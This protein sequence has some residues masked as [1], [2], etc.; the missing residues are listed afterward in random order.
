MTNQ[1][2]ALSTRLLLILDSLS[3]SLYTITYVEAKDT[4]EKVDITKLN[5]EVVET[6][7]HEATL[8]NRIDTIVREIE[9]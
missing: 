6:V 8:R 3:S 5:V 9:G 1:A 7:T 2:F 4:H